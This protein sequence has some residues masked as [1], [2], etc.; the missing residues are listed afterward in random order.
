MVLYHLVPGLGE[1][2]NADALRAVLLYLPGLGLAGL[3]GFFERFIVQ[4]GG[5]LISKRGTPRSR[6]KGIRSDFC[7]QIFTI[8]IY[9]F[10][11]R[12]CLPATFFRRASE[13]YSRQATPGRAMVDLFE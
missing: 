1:G 4:V 7:L 11:P 10:I 6:H 9:F 5:S 3:L 13:P 2:I 8:I 12:K